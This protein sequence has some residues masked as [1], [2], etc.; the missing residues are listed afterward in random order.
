[1]SGYGPGG[2]QGGRL[3]PVVRVFEHGGGV[4]VPGVRGGGRCAGGGEP[5]GWTEMPPIPDMARLQF[6]RSACQI[7]GT[8]VP[9]ADMNLAAGEAIYFAHHVILWKDPQVAVTLLPLAGAFKRMLAGLPI[10]M[11]QAA[12]PG[13][14]A[15][16]SDRPGELIA[17]PLHPHMSVDV[18]EHTLLVATAQVRYDWFS[19]NVWFVTGSGNDSETHYPVGQFMDRFTAGDQPLSAARG[20]ECLRAPPGAGRVDPGEAVGAALQGA[21]RADE[22]LR[23]VFARDADELVDAQPAPP[24][25]A[26]ARAGA[27]GRGVGLRAFPRPR[28]GVAADLGGESVAVVKRRGKGKGARGNGGGPHSAAPPITHC[29]GYPVGTRSR[30]PSPILGEGRCRGMRRWLLAGYLRVP[31]GE[32]ATGVG[33][34]GPGVERVE[35][36]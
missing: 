31:H 16:S 11:T 21:E 27:G 7:E 29:G 17:L 13:H 24:L 33:L 1:M 4:V 34:P 23:R 10:L 6:G 3:L 14:I 32:R 5:V 12:G 18:R 8:Y 20:W 2:G 28:H 9:V 19:S 15:F 36:G 26:T 30:H 25:A 22:S 35:R